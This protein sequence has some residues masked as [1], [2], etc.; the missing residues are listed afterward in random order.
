MSR[1]SLSTSQGVDSAGSAVPYPPQVF[2]IGLSKGFLQFSLCICGALLLTGCPRQKNEACDTAR[3]EARQLA[4]EGATAAA[5]QKLEEARGACNPKLE[6]D[7]VRI[8][9][10]IEVRE[11]QAKREAEDRARAEQEARSQPLKPF[12]DWIEAVREKRDKA[13][14]DGATHSCDPHG[15]PGYGFCTTTLASDGGHGSYELRYWKG[16]SEHIYRFRTQVPEAVECVDLG[17]HRVVRSWRKGELGVHHCE[18]LGPAVKGL[19]VLIEGPAD[20]TDA[21]HSVTV[22]SS[23]YLT[24]DGTLK[25]RLEREWR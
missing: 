17:E 7:L 6:Y 11:R 22:F 8:Q 12:L 3:A 13:K 25:N 15:S 20:K 4:G 2:A 24:R 18:L 9:K 5:K 19:G 16:E 1:L 10:A 14:L 21:P 23:R